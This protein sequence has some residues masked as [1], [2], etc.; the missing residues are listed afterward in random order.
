MS[1]FLLKAYGGFAASATTAVTFP[2]DTETALIAQGLAT[3]GPVTSFTSYVGAPDNYV[4]QGGNV[5]LAPQAGQ[6][7]PAAL[8]GKSIITTIALG[9]AALTG[10]E[11]LGV[12]QVAGTTNLTEI[13]VTHWNT[14]KGV[15]VLQGTTVGTNKIIASIYGGNGALIA[16]SAVAGVTTSGASTFLKC[17]FLFPTVLA[18]GRYFIGI[19]ADGATDTLRHILSAN[20]NDVMTGA[21]AGTFATVLSTITVPSTFTTAQGN[22]AQ[23]YTV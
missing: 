23:L 2:T 16:N 5:A 7:T 1:V 4:T 11:T 15:A 14:W 12:A 8:Q 18:P 21:T 19:Q 6:G 10:Y 22:I 20:G 17:D 3:A 9:S 13:F